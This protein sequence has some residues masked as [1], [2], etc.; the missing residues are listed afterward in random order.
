MIFGKS[1]AKNFTTMNLNKNKIVVLSI[2]LSLLT[3]GNSMHSTSLQLKSK[4]Y[5]H[6][7]K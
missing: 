3:G 2:L 7:Y 1:T 5:D 6:S 4:L